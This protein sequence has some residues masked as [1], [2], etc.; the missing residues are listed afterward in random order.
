[1]NMTQTS[2]S[3]VPTSSDTQLINQNIAYFRPLINVDEMRAILPQ[4]S[5]SAK[6]ILA[7]RTELRSILAGKDK[8]FVVIAGPC[9]IHDPAAAKVYAEKLKALSLAVSDELLLM[10]R[11]YFE[12][13]RTT[14]GWKGFINDPHM[15]GSF[16]IDE[17]LK[18]ARKLLLDL[19]YLEL[20]T[21]T[22][23]LDPITAAYLAELVCW[24]A[25]GARTTES[26]IHREM[27][28]GL[29][30]PVGFKNSTRGDMDIAL[31]AIKSSSSPHSFLGTDD[32]G[33]VSIVRTKGNPDTHIVLR[34]GINKPNYYPNEIKRAEDKLKTQ[35]LSPRIMVDCSHDNSG[36]NH[37][38]QKM[39]VEDIIAQKQAGNQSIF[40]IMLESHLKAGNQKLTRDKNALKFG[41]SITDTCIGWEETETLVYNLH[42]ALKNIKLPQ[43][44]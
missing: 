15:D 5:Q 18:L 2:Q 20:Y 8:R 24:V 17:G 34:G 6:V 28:S 37:E 41:V 22:E 40:G 14:T 10:M 23:I 27:V 12:K 1:M 38:K 42:K 26:Q 32:R 31:N 29:S 4:S 21:A 43:P 33:Q 9:S 13:P 30:T 44:A 11:V 7:G 35:Q 39:V 19:S 25:I 16:K 3:P 36:K